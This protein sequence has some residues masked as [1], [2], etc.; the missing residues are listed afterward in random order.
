MA[1]WEGLLKG[2]SLFP[3]AVLSSV[4][5]E[6][7]L[8]QGRNLKTLLDDPRA[9]L[10]NWERI[11]AEGIDAKYLEAEQGKQTFNAMVIFAVF[12]MLNGPFGFTY[13]ARFN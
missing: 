13:V 2:E 8:K 6:H 10:F 12:E 11:K 1:Q 4:L 5:P 3:G 9:D 7:D